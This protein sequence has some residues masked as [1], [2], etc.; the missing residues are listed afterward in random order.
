MF[1]KIFQ[2]LTGSEIAKDED[3]VSELLNA[4]AEENRRLQNKP[5]QV[6]RRDTDSVLTSLLTSIHSPQSPPDSVPPLD[7]SETDSEPEDPP[8]SPW[9]NSRGRR[10]TDPSDWASAE[11]SLPED[12]VK[13]C[14][15][16]R[17]E[18]FIKFLI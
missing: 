6:Y 11:D 4:I 7:V 14:G 18:C 9:E 1:F 12:S 2:S 3:D 16:M 5:P 17:A 13:R 10:G 8:D 15:T